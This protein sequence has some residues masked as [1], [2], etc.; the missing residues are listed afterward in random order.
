MCVCLSMCLCLCVSMCRLC[1][2]LCVSMSMSVCL[3]LA[4]YVYVSAC[5]CVSVCPS[6]STSM[7]MCLCVYVSVHVCLCVSVYVH[8]SMSMSM[9]LC[10]A[11]SGWQVNDWRV[12]LRNERME[13]AEGK[14]GSAAQPALKTIWVRTT[15]R[16][17]GEVAFS[18]NC[19]RPTI[20]SL[21]SNQSHHQ[22]LSRVQ[23]DNAPCRSRFHFLHCSLSDASVPCELCNVL[24]CGVSSLL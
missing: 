14:D 23:S 19:S 9:S 1:L 10:T 13:K 4:V 3:C 6:M 7:S 8:V 5:L 18:Y 22:Y 21:G 24:W 17:R 15:E 16:W 12:E 11:L 2:Y 20:F